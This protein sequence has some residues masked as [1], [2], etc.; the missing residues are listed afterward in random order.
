M[1]SDKEEQTLFIVYWKLF[2]FGLLTILILSEVFNFIWLRGFENPLAFSLFK[3]IFYTFSV[4]ILK[5]SDTAIYILLNQVKELNE[6]IME[7]LD[8]LQTY[9]NRVNE[10]PSAQVV[11]D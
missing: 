3:L 1:K 5:N 9:Q 8:K 4:I 10:A 7:K 6:V 2:L 11:I